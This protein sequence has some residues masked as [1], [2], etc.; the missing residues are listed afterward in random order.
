MINAE[1][2]VNPVLELDTN[3]VSFDQEQADAD[4]ANDDF[5][6]EFD[7]L[8]RMDDEWQTWLQQSAGTRSPRTAED[9]DRR[10]F[11]FDSLSTPV[12]L[13][14]H[15]MQQLGMVDCSPRIR[16]LVELI[17]GSLDD[18]GF[19]GST[20]EEMS[21]DMRLPLADLQEAKAIVQS[22]DPP[23]VGAE[24]L[25][26]CLLLQLIRNGM[27]HSLEARIV[28]S[29]LDDLGKHRFPVIAKKLGVTPH[30]ITRAAESIGMLNPRPASAFSN[31]PQQMIS[32]DL[33]VEYSAGKFLV[34]MHNEQIPRLR[35]SNTYKDIMAQPS[36]GADVKEYIRDKI[37]SGKFLIRSI[38][39]RQQ[40]IQKIAE[41][42]VAR[43]HSFFMEGPS[44][45]K[46]M[47]MASVAATVGVHETTVSRAIAGKYM[48][49]PQGILEMRSFF[50]AGLSTEE[51][52]ELSNTSVKAALAEL[53]RAED[54]SSPL[55]DDELGKLLNEK[56]IHIARRTVA[57]YREALGILSS[58][59]RRKF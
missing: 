43:Q 12:T 32:P 8:S 53:I 23:G 11:L 35:I 50:T 47:T 2:T 27:E 38:E 26:E 17:I 58:S 5:A 39:Q 57:K 55:S 9:E 46:P 51:G 15:L 4:L 48:A 3:D 6:A 29:H 59:M 20:L 42:I 13:Q 52:G 21:L 30:E 24:S 36:G 45:L 31:A 40:T 28:T 54:P 33:S 16:L 22:F 49:T 18:R 44:A 7:H 37:R 25:K 1:L 34:V 19:T 14:E 56:G 41:E 10:Q